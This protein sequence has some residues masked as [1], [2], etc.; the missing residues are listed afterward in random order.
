MANFHLAQINIA[1]MVHPI[2]D[3]RMA[4]FVALLAPVNALADNAPG[5]VWRL[6]GDSGNA[7]DISYEDDPFILV[8]MS[9][10]ESVEALRDFTYKGDHLK[11]YRDR[12]NWFQKVEAPQ[13]CL[14]WVPA[15][16]VPT[17][18]EGRA[19]LEHYQKNG[20]TPHA[21]W[22]SKLYPAPAAETVSA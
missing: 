3:P 13:Y 6:Q 17:V 22:F 14:W 7:T 10:W 9:V 12:R 11:V 19:R 5:F 1:R 8:N 15:G 20:P 4:D 2:D 16:H 18:A 21:F